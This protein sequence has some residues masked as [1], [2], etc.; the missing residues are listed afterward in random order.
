MKGYEALP[1]DGSCKTFDSLCEDV[2]R[3]ILNFLDDHQDARWTAQFLNRRMAPLAVEPHLWEN[4][5]FADAELTWEKGPESDFHM[6]RVLKKVGKHMK[7]VT[8]AS[9]ERIDGLPSVLVGATNLETLEIRWTGHLGVPG[10]ASISRAAILARDMN[11]QFSLQ[12]QSLSFIQIQDV[13]VTSGALRWL[14]CCAKCLELSM[15][16][17]EIVGASVLYEEEYPCVKHVRIRSTT[18]RA[19]AGPFDVF[20]WLSDATHLTIE[21]CRFLTAHGVDEVAA[22][23][24][25]LQSI[26]FIDI[27]N[28]GYEVLERLPQVNSL[29]EILISNCGISILVARRRVPRV[30]IGEVSAMPQAP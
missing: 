8:L 25:R 16:D 2:L 14:V 12:S 20:H 30:R 23:L 15:T 1:L 18:L 17:V 10:P 26:T 19:G 11:R 21:R 29:Q 24:Q 28:L 4:V 9:W 5:W 3:L 6:H 7:K 27:P 22:S 13:T